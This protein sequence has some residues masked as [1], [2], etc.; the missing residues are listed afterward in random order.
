[1]ASQLLHHANSGLTLKLVGDKGV[2]D[3]MQP[4]LNTV[5]LGVLCHFGGEVIRVDG[6]AIV[7]AEKEF[8]IV[9]GTASGQSVF[10][11]FGDHPFQKSVGR[12]RDGDLS[13]TLYAFWRLEKK[14]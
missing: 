1:M 7:V 6:T 2:P 10:L 3:I 11:I 4:H 5:F 14:S 8:E 9:V 12:G 13:L